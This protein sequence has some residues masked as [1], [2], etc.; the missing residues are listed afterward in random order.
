M[1][2]VLRPDMVMVSVLRPDMVMVVIWLTPPRG[3][4]RGS[5]KA[6]GLFLGPVRLRL[7]KA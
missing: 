1:V 4:P 3:A 2:S 6:T 5:G 7:R